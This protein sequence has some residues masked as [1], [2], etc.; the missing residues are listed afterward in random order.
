MISN[1]AERF[2]I[3]YQGLPDKV[4]DMMFQDILWLAQNDSPEMIYLLLERV[5][6]LSECD[7]P[8]EKILL[9]ALMQESDSLWLGLEYRPQQ[10]IKFDGKRYIA[11]IL[12]EQDIYYTE[13]P[14]KVVI[15]CDGHEFHE[16]TKEQVEKR[17]N[18]DMDL[19][20]QGYDV[21][22]Y[23]GSQIF[24]NPRKCAREITKYIILKAREKAHG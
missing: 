12:F 11:D 1:S 15:E 3:D 5:K 19:K 23:S 22:H 18:R 6:T 7:S 20:M 9:Y 14:Y 13:K 24:K 16:A 4:K 10:V 2:L 21:L 17:N 8:I